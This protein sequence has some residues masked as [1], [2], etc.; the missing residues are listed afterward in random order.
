MERQAKYQGK[1][2]QQPYWSKFPFVLRIQF[3]IFIWAYVE[4]F[5]VR[6]T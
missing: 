5:T 4:A 1:V 6:T 2:K 3:D